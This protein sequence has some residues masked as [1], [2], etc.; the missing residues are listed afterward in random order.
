MNDRHRVSSGKEAAADAAG[1]YLLDCLRT[2]LDTRDIATCALSGGSTP[3]LMFRYLAEQELP[4]ER[5]HFFWVDERCVSPYHEESNFGVTKALLLDPLGISEQ[6]I[7]RIEGEREPDDAADR[8]VRE[9]GEFFDLSAGQMPPFDVLHLG[10]GADAHTAS[11]F[12]GSELIRDRSG[13]AAA[14]YVAARSAYRVTLLPRAILE[15]RRIFFLV[16]GDDKQAALQAVIAGPY[17]P[18]SRPAQ[19]F[20]REAN[21]VVWFLD[22]AS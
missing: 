14:V 17:E 7:H 15:A 21:D 2:A 5:V 20:D 9:I 3:A 11:L 12:P 10:M 1:A 22:Q 4:W 13:I 6:Q 8:Y 16:T 19:L 18:V